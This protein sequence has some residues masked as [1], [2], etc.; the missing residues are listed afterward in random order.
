MSVGAFSLKQARDRDQMR[1][2]RGAS[3]RASEDETNLNVNTKR[4]TRSGARCFT[5]AAKQ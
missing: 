3:Q 5:P 2:L 4:R 1:W